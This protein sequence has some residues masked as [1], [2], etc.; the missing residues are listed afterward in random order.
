MEYIDVG[1]VCLKGVLSYASTL[2]KKSVI[3][4][5]VATFPNDAD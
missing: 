4:A 3:G 2:F 5:Q 1:I